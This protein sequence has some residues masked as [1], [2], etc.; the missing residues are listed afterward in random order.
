MYPEIL[1][2]L[3]NARNKSMFLDLQQMLN[4]GQC[5]LPVLKSCGFGDFSRI[6][7]LLN[8]LLL[9]CMQTTLGLSRSLKILSS[10]N[11]PN[12]LKWTVS[13]FR[14]NL[15]LMPFLYLKSLLYFSLLI[16]SPKD[17]LSLD[18]SFWLPNCCYMTS[19]H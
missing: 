16:S 14:M 3:G 8:P 2:F 11:A 5:L 13:L 18:I 10:I 12:I 7:A 19:W 17:F 6:S 15:S 9:P 4:I 1:S